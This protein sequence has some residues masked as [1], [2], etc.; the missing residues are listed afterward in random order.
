MS[1]RFIFFTL[2]TLCFSLNAFAEVEIKRDYAGN[3]LSI[4]NVPAK[5]SPFKIMANREVR[6]AGEIADDFVRE[7]ASV[8]GIKSFEDELQV[9]REKV[10]KTGTTHITYSQFFD[11]YPVYSAELV[12]H[13]GEDLTVKS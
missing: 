10:D 1:I 4:K 3:I 11:G 2:L 12:V 6:S 8:F 9:T 7:Y 13:V 5:D